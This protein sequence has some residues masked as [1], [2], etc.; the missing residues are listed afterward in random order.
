[1]EE[2]GH[3]RVILRGLEKV[4]KFRR[5]SEKRAEGGADRLRGLSTQFEVLLGGGGLCGVLVGVV[6][7][8]FPGM[9][10]GVGGMTVRYMS[11]VAGLLMVARFMMIGGGVVML[12]GKLVV[13]GGF[14]MMI[15]SL[16]RHG[17][18]LSE[19]LRISLEG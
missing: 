4:T 5:D 11:M 8:C 7:A 1:L 16:L 3:R 18:P 10:R 19:I 12:G 17:E 2:C 15:D 13:F 6:L 9:M 14:A